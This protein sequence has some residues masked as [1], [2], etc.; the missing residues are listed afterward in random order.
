MHYLLALYHTHM[1]WAKRLAIMAVLGASILLPS[2]SF[3]SSWLDKANEGGLNTIGSTAYG[4]NGA[5]SKSLPAIIGSLVKV[6][7]GLL[8]LIFVILL[9][10]GGFQYMTAGGNQ[11][12]IDDAVKRIR[13]AVIGLLIVVCAFSITYFITARVIPR[14]TNN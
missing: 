3:A 4:E 2:V 11:E 6:F 10:V 14:I 7:L 13:N 9:I 12:K 1:L 8:G 5:P